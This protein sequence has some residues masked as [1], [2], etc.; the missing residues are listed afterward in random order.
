[1]NY[2]AIFFDFDGV[3]ADSVEIKTKAFATL[4]E[5]FEPDIK[6]KIVDHHR[7]HGGMTRLDKFKHY[8]KEFLSTPLN[9]R[10]LSVLCHR[11]SNLVV[12]EVVAAPEI[13]GASKFL[14]RL[15]AEKLPCFVVSAT[16]DNEIQDIVR[17]R[18]WSHY[19]L[20]VRGASATKKDNLEMLLKKYSLDPGTCLFFGDAES[21]YIAAQ[22]SGVVFIGILPG[23]NAPLLK[24]RPDTEWF[25]N[26]L[27]VME[28]F[29][30]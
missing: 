17:R 20:E 12:D 16:P 2:S 7:M 22:S 13:S 9:S 26:F 24:A 3:L 25:K 23:P 5:S 11:F 18:K 10:E 30:L 15:H 29:A 6:D 27:Y 8:Y 21:D 1:M 28:D 19:F 4:F 14:N